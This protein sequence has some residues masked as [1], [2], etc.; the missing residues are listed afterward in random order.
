MPV[1]DIQG[2]PEF[3]LAKLK[4]PYLLDSVLRVCHLL[5]AFRADG[6]TLHLKDLVERTGLNKTV[7]FRLA[8]TLAAGGL[9]ER[10]GRGA[11]RSRVK[12]A[13]CKRYRI[14]FAAQAEDSPFS[15]TVTE[16]LCREAAKEEID[17]VI[18]NNRY[19]PRVALAN[20]E[21]LIRERVDLAVEFQT[22]EKVA[23]LI[24][25]RF[26]DA[27]IP[28]IALEIPHPGA[29][30]YGVNNYQ[31]GVTSGRVLARWARQH[32]DGVVDEVLLLELRAAGSVPQLRLTG[33]AAGIAEVLP[34]LRRDAFVSLDAK[35]EF[36]H[37]LDAVRRRLRCIPRRRTLIGG[38][39]DPSVLGALRAFDEAGRA[40]D[41]A[42]IGHGAIKEARLEMRRPHTRLIGSV[43]FF[44]ER[45]GATVLRLAVDIL[46]KRHVAPAVYAEHRL[47]TP[48]NLHCIYPEPL[49]GDTAEGF[50]YPLA[51]H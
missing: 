17:L 8:H 44:P 51:L 49:D 27:G 1:P 37:A 36:A 47:V 5:R 23:P 22:F 12:W 32:W 20:V 2:A 31:V 25:S 35:G 15:Q 7:V 9:I 30:Y 43:A 3:P 26:H 19:S 40:A 16:G 39:N 28:L 33:M 4:D 45:Y 13:G 41:C 11:Y 6:E 38:I 42:A 21:R 46:M 29:T 10:T 34:A 18:L 48:A 24:A 50:E 14:G